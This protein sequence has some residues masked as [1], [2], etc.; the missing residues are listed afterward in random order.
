MQKKLIAIMTV[1]VCMFFPGTVF[2]DYSENPVLQSTDD[3]EITTTAVS[4]KSKAVVLMD[5]INGNVLYK[6]NEREKRS[7]ASITK[8]MTLLLVMEAVESGR[9]KLNEVVSCSDH[10]A[11]MGGSQIWLEPGER[12]TV[13]DLIKATA[14]NSANDAAVALAEFVAGSE[15]SFV[16]LMNRRAKELSMNDTVF[17]NACGLDAEGHI[18][19]ALDIAIMA[20]ELIAHQLVMDYSKI[21]TDT[22]RNGKT[23]L[24][25]TNKLIKTYDGATGLKTGYTETAGYCLAATALRGGLPLIAVTL[26]SDTIDDRNQTAK[27]LLDYGFANYT[28]YTP[29]ADS[30]S[31]KNIKVLK[32]VKNEVS[33]K[34]E[35]P[36]ALVV[37]KGTEKTIKQKLEL[38]QDLIA[39]V[40]KGQTVGKL[41]FVSDAKVLCEYK[42]LA[43]ENI[44]RMAFLPALAMLFKEFFRA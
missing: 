40:D 31:L 9:I 38:P 16:E 3:I 12:M 34:A 29:S 42:I 13:D 25:N 23:E 11:S 21:W 5:G 1:I 6:Q 37:P 18:T 36:S 32:G 17:K 19:S 35:K 41:R 22:L 2:A 14:V 20:K 30:G 33:L 27:A 28:V 7:P 43:A 39:P 4:V 8:I 15:E 24:A 26:G 10:A 44:E